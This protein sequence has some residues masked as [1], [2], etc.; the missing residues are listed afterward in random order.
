MRVLFIG[1]SRI[2]CNDVPRIF[3][4]ICRAEGVET[5]I[6]MLAHG[7][8]GWGWVKTKTRL[9]ERVLGNQTR[10]SGGIGTPWVICRLWRRRARRSSAW[11]KRRARAPYLL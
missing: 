1:N 11:P 9:R 6:A 4:Q 5:A 8:V 2:Y 10:W 3:S 7:G